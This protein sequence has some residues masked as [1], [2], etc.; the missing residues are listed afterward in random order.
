MVYVCTSS[1][2]GIGT[3][4]SVI[5]FTFMC[6]CRQMMMRSFPTTGDQVYL[7]SLTCFATTPQGI[8]PQKEKSY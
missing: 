6:V 8:I 2:M 7:E 3:S 4:L 5:V 1:A